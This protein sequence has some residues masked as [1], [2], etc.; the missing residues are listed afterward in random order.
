MVTKLAAAKIA[1]AAGCR[2]AIAPGTGVHPLKALGE[3]GP[4][5]WFLP[6]ASPLGARKRWIAGGL[7][8]AGA[9]TIDA[10][11]VAALGRGKSLL[12][13]GVT[14]VSGEFQRGDLVRVL[15][16][17]GREIARGLSAYAAADIAR[18]RGRRSADIAAI[19]G[20]RGRDEV[21]H[22]DDLVM[23]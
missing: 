8:P 2:M 6:Q 18:I 23:G 22:R 20:Y 5:T 12:P 21:I 9:L 1:L 7:A 11:A 15:D 3:G 14:S 17:D 10:G 16:L 4:A 13:A 19:L